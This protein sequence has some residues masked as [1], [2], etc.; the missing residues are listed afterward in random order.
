MR[1]EEWKGELSLIADKTTPFRLISEVLYSVGQAGFKNFR[2]V[3]I[4]P[5]GEE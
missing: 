3:T 2:L 1:G 5:G 4:K